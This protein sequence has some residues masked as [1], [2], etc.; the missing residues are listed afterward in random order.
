MRPR[1]T[2][3]FGGLVTVAVAV[4]WFLLSHRVAHTATGTAASESVG[5]ILLAMLVLSII[6]SVR[7][8][9]RHR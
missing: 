3:T 8:N 2:L 9:G 6:G 5:A 4:G 1:A 7:R